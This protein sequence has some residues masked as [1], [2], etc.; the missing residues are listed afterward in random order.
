VLDFVLKDSLVLFEKFVDLGG[1]LRVR[2]FARRETLAHQL[3]GELLGRE[4]IDLA[5]GESQPT[6][7]LSGRQYHGSS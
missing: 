6:R 4:A 5:A 1:L 7:V 2:R 3:Q